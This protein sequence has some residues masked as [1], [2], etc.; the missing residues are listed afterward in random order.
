MMNNRGFKHNDGLMVIAAIGVIAALIAPSLADY[1]G[2]DGSG[3]LYWLKFGVILVVSTLFTFLVLMLIFLFLTRSTGTKEERINRQLDERCAD[4]SGQAFISCRRA[5]EDAE[6]YQRRWKKPNNIEVQQAIW[7]DKPVENPELFE[8][9]FQA[10]RAGDRDTELALQLMYSSWDLGEQCYDYE[11]LRK[12]GLDEQSFI[13]GFQQPFEH[14]GGYNSENP[15]LLLSA[16]HMISLFDYR[17]GLTLNDAEK[18]FQRFL[19]IC[20]EGIPDVE[21]E[22]RGDFGR[23]FTHIIGHRKL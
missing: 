22:K 13:T 14:L 3:T 2:Q 1:L 12:R 10:W 9:L 15:T 20:L 23:Y 4:L 5:S 8:I 17:T 19:Q 16:G 21:F 11:E 6:T 7:G 18:C